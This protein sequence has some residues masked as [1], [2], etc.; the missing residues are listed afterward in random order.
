MKTKDVTVSEIKSRIEEIF[1]KTC[2]HLKLSSEA[3]KKE[4]IDFKYL[5]K[6]ELVK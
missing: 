2:I 4:F 5:S 6:I 3:A 1:F